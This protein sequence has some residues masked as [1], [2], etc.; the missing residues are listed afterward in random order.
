MDEISKKGKKWNPV[1]TT[2]GTITPTPTKVKFYKTSTHKSPASKLFVTFPKLFV[3]LYK[4]IIIIV[5]IIVIILLY[6]YIIYNIL[7]INK[8]FHFHHLHTFTHSTP[9]LLFI[10]LS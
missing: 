4:Y 6:Y 7:Y 1:P 8:T 2:N 9:N 3:I 10:I 5:I